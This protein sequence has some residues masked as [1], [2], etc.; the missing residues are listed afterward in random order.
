MGQT[1]NT[2][3]SVSSPISYTL[4]KEKVSGETAGT[5][6]LP[7]ADSVKQS[8]ASS[9]AIPSFFARFTGPKR[10]LTPLPSLVSASGEHI[11]KTVADT[12][13]VTSLKDQEVINPAD[14]A[15]IHSQESKQK[16][17]AVF[18]AVCSFMFERRYEKLPGFNQACKEI[19]TL[20]GHLE[21]LSAGLKK[22]Q[23]AK[24][25]KD[26]FEEN[27]P[28]NLSASEKDQLML[29]RVI[30]IEA[31]LDPADLLLKDMDG[32]IKSRGQHLDSDAK[33][34]IMDVGL[35]ILGAITV[36]FAA[37]GFAMVPIL[38]GAA[39][40]IGGAIRIPDWFNRQNLKRWIRFRDY[41]DAL[42]K[43][44][45]AKEEKV[46]LKSLGAV[47]LPAM[48]ELTERVNRVLNDVDN[49]REDV[50][51]RLAKSADSIDRVAGDVNR[52]VDDVNRVIKTVD[53][54]KSFMLKMAENNT[55]TIEKLQAEVKELKEFNKKKAQQQVQT[56][57]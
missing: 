23:D 35:T 27:Y 28:D 40:V 1:I 54:I 3:F 49:Q 43:N 5:C 17:L 24:I 6:A 50:N 48:S 53:D 34:F 56:M 12:V 16:A 2:K 46:V 32:I 11:S 19:K 57:A 55:A 36:V 30:E 8:S 25:C 15:A 9:S 14:L 33:S 45:P 13:L 38:S 21:G 20:K 52:A 18:D 29:E 10:S 31:V 51:N 44:N 22:L 26:Y 37:Y 42:S 4:L 7:E 47:F 39:I 41:L